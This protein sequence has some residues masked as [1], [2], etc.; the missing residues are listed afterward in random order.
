M[1]APV[2]A[3][4]LVVS[5]LHATAALRDEAER[6]LW[7]MTA[8]AVLTVCG[9]ALLLVALWWLLTGSHPP[10]LSAFLRGGAAVG[11]G[12]AFASLRRRDHTRE[13]QRAVEAVAGGAQV[14]LNHLL[15]EIDGAVPQR[16]RLPQA[17]VAKLTAAVLPAA[18]VV[19]K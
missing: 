4:G 18:R 7:W 1:T 12:G 13:L 6:H 9:G 19:P 16:I 17:A 11:I 3:P 14:R 2:K 15:L 10:L 8:F 5:K